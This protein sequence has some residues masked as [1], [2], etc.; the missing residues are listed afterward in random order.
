M[1]TEWRDVL[2]VS[3]ATGK[4]RIFARGKSQRAADSLVAMAVYRRGLDD[5][6]FIDVPE[7]QYAEGDSYPKEAPDAR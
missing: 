6:F 7:G 1:D 3:R 2:A 5:E 4:V